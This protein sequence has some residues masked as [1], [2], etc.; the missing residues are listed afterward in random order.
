MYLKKR[1]ET[2]FHHTIRK[3]GYDF[4]KCKYSRHELEVEQLLKYY[5][6][7]TVLDVGAN[8]GQYGKYLR[9]GGYQNHIISFEPIK[10]AFAQL[11]M[12]AQKDPKWN[13]YNCAI[14]DFDGKTEINLS[15]NSVSSSIR[16][17]KKAHLDSAPNSSYIGKQEIEIHTIDSLFESFQIIGQNNFMKIDTQGF[18]KNVL[19]GASNSLKYINTLQLEMSVQPLYEGED[20]YFQLSEFLYKEGY[21]LIK[22]VRG[23]TKTNGE[24]LQ[25]DGI[26]RRN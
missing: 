10:E 18:E 19:V 5:N 4:V 1:L 11:N 23:H 14:G 26:F 12:M 24:L 16:D 7:A 6:I 20:L 3:T 21:R 25:F 8:C 2:I 17:I 22:I 15:G 9:I 13:V